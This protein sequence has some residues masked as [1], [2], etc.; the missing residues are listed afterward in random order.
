METNQ[1]P[2][3][4]DE[5]N[6]LVSSAAYEVYSKSRPVMINLIKELF[7]RGK[8]LDEVL[9]FVNLKCKRKATAANIQLAAEYIYTNNLYQ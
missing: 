5:L 9:E 7:K 8:A 2:T 3:N 1:A 6:S 4:L